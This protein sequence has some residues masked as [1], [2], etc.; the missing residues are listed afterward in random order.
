M[1]LDD[2]AAVTDTWSGAVRS[3]LDSADPHHPRFFKWCAWEVDPVDAGARLGPHGRQIGDAYSVNLEPDGRLTPRP[4]VLIVGIRAQADYTQYADVTLRALHSIY[5]AGIPVLLCLF[6]AD[7]RGITERT[8]T[9]TD[10]PAGIESPE[11]IYVL[12]VM[13][14]PRIEVFGASSIPEFEYRRIA[15]AVNA[16]LIMK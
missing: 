4:D 1:S 11:L 9:A 13:Y 2:Q 5:G 10:L 16:I 15:G 14:Q 8:P 7:N 12:P 6:Y 3:S